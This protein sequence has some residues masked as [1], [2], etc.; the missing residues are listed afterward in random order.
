MVAK[1]VEQAS[2][3][4]LSYDLISELSVIQLIKN[5]PHSIKLNRWTCNDQSNYFIIMK[6]YPHDG[7][8]LSNIIQNSSNIDFKIVTKY[9]YNILLSLHQLHSK[10]IVHLDIKPDNILSDGFDNPVL[11][12]F[13]LSLQIFPIV[14]NLHIHLD[15]QVQTIVY[16]APEIFK[17]KPFDQRVDIWSLGLFFLELFCRQNQ[18]YAIWVSDQ[19]DNDDTYGIFIQKFSE[20]TK[21]MDIIINNFSNNQSFEVDIETRSAFI[22]LL[23]NMLVIDPNNRFNLN[24]VINHP[25]FREFNSSQI[26]KILE[27]NPI[28]MIIKI[29][30]L[31]QSDINLSELVDLSFLLDIMLK[32]NL[33][34][35]YFF[36]IIKL[37]KLV[38]LSQG[39]TSGV[40]TIDPNKLIY[41]G[42]LIR[43]EL[44]SYFDVLSQLEKH[45][46][47]NQSDKAHIKYNQS[48]IA[49]LLNGCFLFP[50]IIDYLRVYIAQYK[51]CLNKYHEILKI[52]RILM[53]FEFN[54]DNQYTLFTDSQKIAAYLQ[55]LGYQT[56]DADINFVDM[57]SKVAFLFNGETDNKVIVN[58]KNYLN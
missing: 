13:G 38:L 8:T 1:V 34:F 11:C 47:I 16:R 53:Y 22:D 5:N 2:K 36:Y 51:L 7:R 46:L 58:I 50:T 43:A 37:I 27:L 41:A 24:Q 42:L 25:F 29:D 54:H 49:K 28:E 33:H 10:F 17:F 12:D 21:N 30:P 4:C 48:I 18:S 26:P 31:Q 35:D 3:Q 23:N 55:Y 45:N 56:I 9:M 20:E 6:K 32:L 15:D 39:N 44:Y 40:T 52:V 57:I 19:E 14:R